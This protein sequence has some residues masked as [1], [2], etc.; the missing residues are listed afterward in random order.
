MTNW[1]AAL[2]TFVITLREGVEAALVV[3]IILSLLAQTQRQDLNRWVWAAVA[4]GIAGSAMIGG[5]FHLLFRWVAQSSGAF[6]QLIE[7]LL[8]VGFTVS[9]IALLSWM[10]I[11][12]TEQAKSMK[13]NLEGE[14][15][16]RLDDDA[17]GWAV[18]GL[19]SIAVLREGFETAV[20]LTTQEQATGVFGAIAGALG[21]VIIG[22]MLFSLGIKLN[23]KRF[24]Q[25]MGGF[26]IL[27]VAG[28][29]MSV[30]KSLD[31]VAVALETIPQWQNQLCIFT[32]ANQSCLWGPLVWNGQ[33]ILP[34]QEF[35]GLVLK[36]LL[37]YRDRIYLGQG[38]AYI[39]FLASLTGLYLNKLNITF[40]PS[41][42][43]AKSESTG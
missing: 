1:A 40:N 29:V 4:A 12:M 18:F 38:I 31:A 28:L 43:R 3:G 17:A 32:S 37:G 27:I 34:D 13:T 22:W 7:P 5:G 39:F 2:P 20:F 41:P 42:K 16:Q 8:K 35:P 9:A 11:W 26:L 10:L 33:S 36:A 15:Q 6:A 19:V 23:L 14:I 30:C 25:F 21:A 24:F